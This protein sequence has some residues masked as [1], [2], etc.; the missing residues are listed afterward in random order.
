MLKFT[1]KLAEL[2]CDR[3]VYTHPRKGAPGMIATPKSNSVNQG[4]FLG[5]TNRHMGEELQEMG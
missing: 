2:I 3:H 5:I 1:Y 4:A